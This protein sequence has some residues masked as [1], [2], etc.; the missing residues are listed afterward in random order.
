MTK[1]NWS[2]HVYTSLDLVPIVLISVFSIVLYTVMQC[3][4]MGM[5]LGSKKA[6][7][8]NHGVLKIISKMALVVFGPPENIFRYEAAP[9]EELDEQTG[10]Q[11]VYIRRKRVSNGFVVMLGGYVL[12]FGLFAVMVFWDIFL[13][14]ES[15]DCDDT[16]ID[17]FS[18]TDIANASSGLIKDCAELEM[19]TNGTTLITCY[20]FTFAFGAALG[21]IGGLL[22]MI[23]IVMKIISSTFLWA[24]SNAG[25]NCKCCSCSIY[26]VLIFHIILVTLI[27][28]VA[29]II[30][31]LI[32]VG[33]SSLNYNLSIA[34]IIQ[35]VLFM[36]TLLIGI[37]FPWCL[38][39]DDDNGSIQ[40][41]LF[42]HKGR[43]DDRTPISD[44]ATHDETT[45]INT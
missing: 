20:T 36:L 3:I 33:S 25:D 4:R 16:T 7:N 21:A 2:Q 35:V 34:N 14:S 32:V 12:T 24:Y 19:Q 26:C 28:F 1:H 31:T 13:L 23:R 38:F 43:A 39:I 37:S 45:P 18:Q 8:V 15:H 5:K 27:P 30:I 6:A 44:A 42:G 11:V 29:A 41:R 9:K 22:T 17:C 40:E 10:T